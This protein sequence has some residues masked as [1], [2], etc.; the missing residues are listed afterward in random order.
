VIG[1]IEEGV[2]S[3]VSLI[4]KKFLEL[5]DA[6]KQEAEDAT[7]E[8]ASYKTEIEV[9][10]A[11]PPPEPKPTWRTKL[12][13]LF[14]AKPQ[15]YQHL[16]GLQSEAKSR[17]QRIAGLSFTVGS[18]VSTT[19]ALVLSPLTGIISVITFV[20]GAIVGV[21]RELWIANLQRRRLEITLG[22]KMYQM[23]ARKE[24]SRRRRM[25][26][27]RIERR[28]EELGTWTEIIRTVVNNPFNI[29]PPEEVDAIQVQIPR[30][31]AFVV[32]IGVVNDLAARNAAER[33]RKELFREGWLQQRFD[34]LETEFMVV[35]GSQSTKFDGNPLTPENDTSRDREAL[36]W[37][38]LDYF[39]T[40]IGDAARDRAFQDQLQ[41]F[42]E[43]DDTNLLIEQ[44][45]LVEAFGD[46]AHQPVLDLH[47]PQTPDEY[48]AEAAAMSTFPGLL[49]KT[50]NDRLT[51]AAPNQEEGT[52]VS[53][54]PRVTMPRAKSK[55][56]A[57]FQFASVAQYSVAFK[58]ERLVMV[59][60]LDQSGTTSQVNRSEAIPDVS[61]GS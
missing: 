1:P 6:A 7:V 26:H 61:G 4:E 24:K 56:R 16:Q 29:A 35:Q 53:T 22:W 34:Q 14:R 15:P 2:D 36:R 51:A 23:A 43:E 47:T 46:N 27:L 45:E 10:T 31:Q 49:F 28:I 55:L 38:L 44:I 57:P 37:K 5:V 11:G 33:F 32:S 19:L 41:E 13:R 17:V 21:I 42:L 20:V 48:F 50:P 8:V 52:R 25:D 40:Q 59:Q 18:I 58:A 60:K 3:L 30:P 9:L 54:A 12:K 39:E